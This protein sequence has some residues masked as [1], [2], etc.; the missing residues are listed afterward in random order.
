MEV[1]TPPATATAP[2][3]QWTASEKATRG[4]ERR[5]ATARETKPQRKRKDRAHSAHRVRGNI[6]IATTTKTPRRAVKMANEA[7]KRKAPG[8]HREQR[9]TPH[10]L[11][12]AGRW[13][14]LEFGQI[15]KQKN[16][17]Q[18]D[19]QQDQGRHLLTSRL[20]HIRRSG[21]SK[22]KPAGGGRFGVF[23]CDLWQLLFKGGCVHSGGSNRLIG[24][25]VF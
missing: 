19:I 20:Y 5:Q 18:Q 8:I 16:R 11:R 1:P 23:G 7:R 17:L 15:E 22:S 25:L 24:G 2:P 4:R 3:E 10:S 21:S 14:L 9:K 12:H 6:G 13:S